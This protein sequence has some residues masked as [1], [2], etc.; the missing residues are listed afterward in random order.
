MPR[1]SRFICD[2]GG[3]F[4]DNPGLTLTTYLENPD[5]KI[6]LK[7]LKIAQWASEETLCFRATV[8]VDGVKAGEVSNEGS[9]GPNSYHPHEL[10][11]ALERHA[12]TL[13]AIVSDLVRD[14][15]PFTYRP[16]ADTLIDAAV[17]AAEEAKRIKRLCR[18]STLYRVNGEEYAPG[19]YMQLK[20]PYSEAVALAIRARHPQG[21]TIINEEVSQ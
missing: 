2:P 7:N 14:G 9:G 12:Q 8:Y 15:E 16:S 19:A 4:R 11:Q 21:V 5:V 18:T 1:T 20:R 3:T 13:P 17:E 6:T 10:W